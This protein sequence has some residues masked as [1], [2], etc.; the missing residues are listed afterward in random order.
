MLPAMPATSG[1]KIGFDVVPVTVNGMPPPFD[2]PP[3]PKDESA[4]VIGRMRPAR[5]AGM[6]QLSL[7]FGLTFA[8]PVTV[9]IEGAT[10]FK[11]FAWVPSES[12]RR[13]VLSDWIS[14]SEPP[15]PPPSPGNEESAPSF[16]FKLKPASL[17]FERFTG[18]LITGLS[19]GPLIARLKLRA[20]A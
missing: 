9:P 17:A 20:P 4:E 6:L 16:D 19:A 7:L 5:F 11:L 13:S 12:T 8:L 1:R 18:P 10:I 15:P 2:F 14:V 3:P